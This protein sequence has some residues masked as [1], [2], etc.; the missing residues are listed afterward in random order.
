MS[1]KIRIFVALTFLL[2]GC[3]GENTGSYVKSPGQEKSS[4]TKALEVGADLLQ[5]K[6]P[7]KRMNMYLD[8]FHFY[9]GNMQGQMEAHHYC[10]KINEDLTQCVMF[11]GNGE[12]AKI[13]G[14]E[15]IVSE[16]LFKTLPM[17]ERALWHSHAYEVK[18][19][20]L[21]APG[22]PQVAEHELMEEIVSTY[23]KVIHTWHT[24]RDLE[25]PM[26]I[27]QIMMGFTQDGQLRAKLLTDRDLR[28]RVNTQKKRQQ[29]EDI[30]MP[31]I[32]PGANAW[33]QG[34]VKQLQ[35]SDKAPAD[36]AH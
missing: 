31:A 36:H 21:I 32:V 9:N 34:N 18:S 10:T 14:V 35:V 13:M 23:G 7:L 11:D 27:P 33:E 4:K 8:G 1:K 30:P 29:R 26:G 25:L 24:D 15:Y 17:A 19:G 28:F 22:I 6:T 12:N 16:K 20:E 3:G 5:D 2:L